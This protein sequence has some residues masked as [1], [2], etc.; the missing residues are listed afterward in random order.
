MAFGSLI[1]ESQSVF[2]GPKISFLL[3]SNEYLI[4]LK[5]KGLKLLSI[6]IF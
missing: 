6:G 2:K 5:K 4:G 1:N 3:G